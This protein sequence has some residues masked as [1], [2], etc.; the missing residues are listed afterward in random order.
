MPIINTD[1]VLRL[2]VK[3]GSAGDS[4]AS[5]EAASLGKYVAT[6]VI[7]HAALN[8]LFDDTS[9]AE[10]AAGDIEYRCFFVLNNHATLTLANATIEVL[11]QLAGGGSVDLATDNIAV[12]AKGSA[13]AQ[14]AEI[15]NEST[16]PVGVGAYGAGPL[17]L[18]NLGPGQVKAVWARRTVGAGASGA[19]P[20]GLSVRVLGDTLP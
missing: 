18:G 3:T 13:S 10:S 7:T 11:S 14:A 20:D 12:S 2:S 6:T 8:N 9:G 15:A 4:T 1:I 5:S 16:G 17:A 19:D